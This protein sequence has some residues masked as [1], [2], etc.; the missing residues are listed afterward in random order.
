MRELQRMATLTLKVFSSSPIITGYRLKMQNQNS[1]SLSIF[2]LT[3]GGRQ[4]ARSVRRSHRC[5]RRRLQ[6][7]LLPVCQGARTLTMINTMMIQIQIHFIDNDKYKDHLEGQ[8]ITKVPALIIKAVFGVHFFSF[9][10]LSFFGQPPLSLPFQY[11]LNI[12]KGQLGPPVNDKKFLFVTKDE[13][14]LKLG[15]YD[16]LGPPINDEK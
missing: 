3:A 12:K 8:L 6:G 10:S 13:Q 15:P 14:F 5:K 4:R 9:M 7:A 2:N 16:Q 11:N 1:S